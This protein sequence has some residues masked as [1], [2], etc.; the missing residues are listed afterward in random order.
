MQKGT[1]PVNG[2]SDAFLLLDSRRNPIF[3]SS[4]AAQILAY[5][6]LPDLKNNFKGYLAGGL[7]SMFLSELPKNGKTVV[8][9]FQSGRRHYL[10]RTVRVDSIGN[11]DCQ[12]GFALIFE[13]SMTRPTD[14][15]R[16]SNR[17]H[18]TNRER[19]VAQLLSQ[20]LTS[21]EIGTRMQ[22][23]PN[24]VRTFLRMIMVKMGVS[25]RSGILG[26][27]LMIEA[28]LMNEGLPSQ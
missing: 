23:S 15:V 3:I 19:E 21:K 4:A 8:R 9:P 7:R 16:L 6:R 28:P 24:T 25:T 2:S 10:C 14:L 20:G 18:L 27:A 13:R 12:P 17:F 5:P 22:I 1:K 26:K 11:G